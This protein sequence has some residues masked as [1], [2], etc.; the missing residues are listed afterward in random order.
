MSSWI[1]GRTVPA[2]KKVIITNYYDA[3]A[4]SDTISLYLEY[5]SAYI[6]S[7]KMGEVCNIWDPNAI[8]KN[9]LRQHPQ[10][11]FLKE[12]S[13]EASA[14]PVSVFSS[15]VSKMKMKD[16]QKI[17]TDLLVYDTDFNRTVVNL[18]QRAGIKTVFDIGIHLVKDISGPNLPAFKMYSELLKEYQK[19]TK[20]EILS[21]Y[22]MAD[23]YSV[24]TQFQSYCDPSWKIMSLCKIPVIDAETQFVQTMADIQIMTAI[25]ALALDFS[26]P[27]DRFIYLMQRTKGGLTYFKEVKNVEWNLI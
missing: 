2:K 10:V 20:K 4:S 21:I 19:K 22:I 16:L 1:V 11:K 13:E 26:R 6:Y 25:P 24:V 23:S 8:L 18:I 5:L 17:A 15:L 27:A 3:T 14:T 7:Q 9:T 12:K